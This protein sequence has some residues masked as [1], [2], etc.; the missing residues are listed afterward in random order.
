MKLELLISAVN[1]E[2]DKL[3]Q[4]MR[5][6]TDAV[7]VNQC[8]RED[9]CEIKTEGG[10]VRVLS[11]AEKGV[12]KS[13]NRAIDAAAGDILLFA[14]DDIVYDDGYAAKIID[15]FQAHP[16]A[17]ALFFNV[18]VCAERRTYLNTDYKRVHIW[19]GG[20]YPAYSIAVRREAIM[21]AGVRFS[22]L[23]GG[24]ARYSC[25]EDSLFIRDCLKSGMKMYRTTVMIGREEPR[26]GGESTWFK[27]Y[28]EKYF[29]D[30][31]VLYAYLYGALASAMG[32]RYVYCKRKIMCRDIPWRKAY[33]ILKKG[34]KEGKDGLRNVR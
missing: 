23:F 3:I 8:G 19:N 28:D 26:P 4:K 10:V 15:E 6:A 12:G 27:G 5:V 13:R 33:S 2:P 14:D 16:E 31:G 32:L 11:F 20:R 22:E 24:G 7:L 21:R 17:D 18:E 29:F 30:R 9:A 34:I 25:G 1:A